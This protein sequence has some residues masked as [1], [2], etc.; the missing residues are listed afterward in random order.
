MPVITVDTSLGP[1]VDTS[2]FGNRPIGV[3]ARELGCAVGVAIGWRDGRVTG[4]AGLGGRI[5]GD[6][7]PENWVGRMT[8]GGRTCETAG[9]G[10][11]TADCCG[12]KTGIDLFGMLVFWSSNLVPE[13]GVFGDVPATEAR[14]RDILASESSAFNAATAGCNSTLGLGR[15]VF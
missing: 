13:L 2:G 5:V 12:C 9:G 6:D 3:E 15:V 14:P 1:G 10:P 4:E 8:V 7:C 11:L